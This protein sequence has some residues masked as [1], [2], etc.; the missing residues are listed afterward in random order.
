MKQELSRTQSTSKLFYF[1][2]NFMLGEE[3][4]VEAEDA[5]SC[6]TEPGAD[7]GQGPPL[8]VSPDPA[9]CCWALPRPLLSLAGRQDWWDP[10]GTIPSPSQSKAW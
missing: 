4:T 3:V 5:W 7:A 1:F 2:G 8:Q 9:F 6:E 10:A